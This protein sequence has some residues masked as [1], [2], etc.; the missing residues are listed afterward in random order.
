MAIGRYLTHHVH[1]CRVEV[2]VILTDQNDEMLSRNS[3]QAKS[4][5]ETLILENYCENSGFLL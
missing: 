4:K 2:S 5:P 3:Q 1:I